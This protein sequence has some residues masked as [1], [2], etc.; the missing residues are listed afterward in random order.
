[1]ENPSSIHSIEPDG[2]NIPDKCSDIV[3]IELLIKDGDDRYV[4]SARGVLLSEALR[5]AFEIMAADTDQ[6]GDKEA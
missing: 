4:R 1:M 2:S 3:P 5:K 6:D